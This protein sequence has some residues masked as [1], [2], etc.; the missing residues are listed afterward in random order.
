MRSLL[1]LLVLCLA[2]AVAAH[3]FVLQPG[4]VAEF[5]VELPPALRR[6]AGGGP[7][8]PV[9]AARVALALPPGF[10]AD[11]PWPVMIVSA[12]AAP[13]SHASSVRLLHLYA[14]PAAAAG[15]V[16]LAADPEAD[17]TPDEDTHALRFALAQAALLAVATRW[18]DVQRAPI[19]FG[20]FSGGAKRSGVLAALFASQGRRPIGVF[21]A[22]INEETV[23]L[24]AKSVQVLDASYRRTPVFLLAGTQDE[25]A[26]V[27]AHE[28]VRRALRRAGFTRVR[29]ETFNGPHAVNAPPL[30]EALQWFSELAAAK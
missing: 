14:R 12:T 16:L 20:G 4:E 2:C 22:G 3:G 25:I 1:R 6:I 28:S 10:A 23:A 5:R 24:L 30:Q 26:S 7:E 13:R 19:A 15:W 29:L 11:R 8:S 21:Q 18:S 17:L 27:E 9:K